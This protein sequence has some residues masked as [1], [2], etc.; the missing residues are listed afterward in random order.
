MKMRVLFILFLILAG[1]GD[2]A[3]Y[4]RGY[5][6]SQSQVESTPEA[7]EAQDAH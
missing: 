3:N 2:G 4:N 6:I 7:E 5:V 1:C